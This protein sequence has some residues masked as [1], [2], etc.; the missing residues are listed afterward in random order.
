MYALMAVAPIFLAV[1]LMVGFNVRSG[2]SM[3]AAWLAGFVFA[4]VFWKLDFM[5]GAAYTLFGFL[6]S[7]DTI[8]IV[9]GAILL[10]NVLIELKFIESIGNGFSNITHDRRIQILIIGW[11]FTCFIEGA[12]GFGTPGALAAPL[13]VGLGVPPF[14]AGLSALIGS[15]A[16]TAFGAVGTPPLTGFNTIAAGIGE[17]F[18]HVDP[19]DFAGQFYSR[20]ALT[21]IF[22]GTFV[23]VLLLAAVI[24]CDGG[25]N[26]LKAVIPILPL[27]IFSGLIFTIPAYF[28]AAFIGPEMPS[29]LGALIGLVIMVTAVKKGFLIPKELWRFQ[30]DPIIEAAADKQVKIPLFTAWSPYLAIAALLAVT[31]L[32]WLP[33][34]D[35]INDPGRTVVI[36][37]IL[38]FEGIDWT[39]RILNNPGIFPFIIVAVSC[40]LMKR[41]SGDTAKAMFKK[42]GGQIKNAAVAL[43]FGI[44]LV[45]IMRYTNYSNPSGELEAMTTEVAKTLAAGF[46]GMYPLISPFVGAFGSIV[47]GSNTVS[48][49]MFMMLQ[50]QAAVLVGLPAVMIAVSQ[51]LGGAI[52][53]MICVHNVVAVT[54]TTGAQGKEG[55][56]IA[57][58]AIPC[59]ICI[60]MLAGILFVYLAIGLSWVA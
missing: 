2:K 38:G 59:I 24:V 45:Q 12:A 36:R 52:G 22:I 3:I 31:R 29:L 27:G 23:P 58:A 28:V 5:H 43:L 34:R 54:A 40:M 37:G 57:A 32:P 10:L 8:I 4:V 44:A 50:F 39:W 26:R 18:P 35:W 11:L 16:P 19:A 48:N 21:N 49:I 33:V 1:V 20:M 53:N 7:L 60:L 15:S 17:T 56:L 6:V 41:M 13:L 46:G 47:A 14:A 42:T 30:N 25:K 51:S 9:F 55:K